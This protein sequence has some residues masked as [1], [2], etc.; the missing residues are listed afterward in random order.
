MT[1]GDRMIEAGGIPHRVRIDGTSGP[2]VVFSNSLGCTLEMWDEQVAVLSAGHRVLRYDTRGHGGSGSTS[3][4]YDF[5]LLAGDLLAILDAVG[6]ERCTL[7]G[8]SMGGMIAQHAA[9]AQPE[10][11]TGLALADT[12]S[13]YGRE[14]SDFWAGRAATALS[15]GLDSIALTTPLRWFT[16]ALVARNPELVRRY[17]RTLR[18]TNPEGYAGCC[19]A[20]PHI[21]TTARLPA[22]DVPVAVIVGEHDPSTTIEHARRLHAAIAGST[23]HIIPEAAH[24]SN[25]EQPEHFT[26]ILLDLLRGTP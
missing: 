4:P 2:W 20:I 24:L 1:E 18:T 11:F 23:L 25:V 7:V 3:G 13:H 26:R 16:P 15:Q 9:L 19:A 10:R 17:Q 5:E 14:V 21:D 12:T 8:L 6:V 22:I